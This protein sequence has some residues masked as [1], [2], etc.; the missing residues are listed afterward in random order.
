MSGNSL[1]L[2][3]V[4]WGR[5]APTHCVSS[6]LVMD[7]LTTIV[8][9]CHDRHICIWDMSSDLEISPRAMFCHNAFI[10]CLS[11]ASPGSEKQYIV[12]SPLR[13]CCFL[14]HTR[15][16]IQCFEEESKPIYCRDCQSISFCNFTQPFLLVV[17]SKYWR[18]RYPLL[19]SIQTLYSV[20][21]RP[22]TQHFVEAPLAAIT[23]LSLLLSL[24]PS[25]CLPLS[26]S[27]S[28]SY[29]LSLSLFVSLSLFLLICP[30]VTRFFYSRRELFHKLLVQGDSAGRLT[31][32]SI[33]DTSPLQALSTLHV[34]STVS[35]Q[36][37][38]DKLAP[39]S[40]GIIDQ[41]SVTPGSEEP[42]KVTSSVY[43]PSQGRLVCGREDGRGWGER[44]VSPRYDQRSLDLRCCGRQRH[45][46]GHTF[47]GEEK[48]VFCVLHGGE[49][50]QLLVPLRTAA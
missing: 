6:L 37:A 43:I 9:G 26:L 16:W 3:I 1:V 34:S 32:W 12:S 14:F 5:T 21:F 2:P 46:P 29:T 17:C 23:A 39:L 10:T 35:L 30:S 7:N 15:I 19:S 50:T 8:A 22:F 45:R 27:L 38:F 47:T 48:H 4:L 24:S 20:V 49:I 41:L 44:T 33:P 13:V 18:E 36:E 25:R 42:I 40:A 31:L 11:K 28:L